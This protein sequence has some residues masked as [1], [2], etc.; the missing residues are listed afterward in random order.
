MEK[1]RNTTIM[2]TLILFSTTLSAQYQSIFGNQQTKWMLNHWGLAPPYTACMPDSMWVVYGQDTTFQAKTFKPLKKSWGNLPNGLIHGYVS[3][4]TTT[5]EVWY[6]NA[7]SSDTTVYNVM[8]MSLTKN[9]TF[10]FKIGSFGV[11]PSLVDTAYFINSRKVIELDY[12]ERIIT[13][14]GSRLVNY[15]MIEGVGANMRGVYSSQGNSILKYHWKD[16]NLNY[17]AALDTFF[18]CDTLTTSLIKNEDRVIDFAIFPNPIR[19]TASIS[20]KE[21]N[22]ERVELIDLSGRLVKS[23][24]VKENELNFSDVSNGVYFVRI[25]TKK[26]EQFT[27]KVVVQK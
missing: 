10:Y 14:N 2:L 12:K 17:V 16:N 22:A 9:D 19:E 26:Q 27:Q 11:V 4:D 21:L 7:S 20:L 18:N 15:T 6:R 24:S 3:E 23:F 5:G 8:N 25:T 13:N 1:L